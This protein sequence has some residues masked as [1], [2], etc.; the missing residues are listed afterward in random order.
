MELLK[1]YKYRIITDPHN[2][3]VTHKLDKIYSF[4][5]S[6]DFRIVESSIIPYYN[7]V[8][9]EYYEVVV[10]AEISKINFPDRLIMEKIIDDINYDYLFYT[11][12]D[13][14]PSESLN[15]S[16]NIKLLLNL[17]YN[18]D[19]DY[20]QIETDYDGDS[21]SITY[22]PINKH[23]NKIYYYSI[24]PYTFNEE[25]IKQY[26]LISNDPLTP[27]SVSQLGSKVNP[28]GSGNIKTSDNMFFKENN[29]NNDEKSELFKE[30]TLSMRDDGYITLPPPY[31]KMNKDQIIVSGECFKQ[32][33][34]IIDRVDP[35]IVG[36][37]PLKILDNLEFPVSPSKWLLNAS[38]D[39]QNN[40]IPTMSILVPSFWIEHNRG[41]TELD[42][43]SMINLYYVS[44]KSYMQLCDKYQILNY[45][46]NSIEVIN[47]HRIKASFC[48][49]DQVIEFKE[50]LKINL[51]VIMKRHNID[52]KIFKKYDHAIA[53]RWKLNDIP[54]IIVSSDKITDIS[55][56]LNDEKYY[57]I[58]S[59]PIG[60]E[61]PEYD[62]DIMYKECVNA[63]Y[64]YNNQ[65]TNNN[66][67][68][69][70][71]TEISKTR[72]M[73]ELLEY[74]PVNDVLYDK[75]S[76]NEIMDYVY[77]DPNN[78][79]YKYSFGIKFSEDMINGYFD[80]PTGFLKGMMKSYPSFTELDLKLGNLLM[81][82]HKI[83]DHSALYTF[84]VAVNSTDYLLPQSN[85]ELIN[86][87]LDKSNNIHKITNLRNRNMTELKLLS[88]YRKD[89]NIL[90]TNYLPSE[91]PGY[92]IS[93]F[94]IILPIGEYTDKDIFK[95]IQEYWR[96]GWMLSP[97]SKYIYK[98]T[99]KLSKSNL[100]IPS[101]LI[102]SSENINKSKLAIQ[103]LNSLIK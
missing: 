11:Y 51:K 62:R 79:I 54:S 61:I 63:Y 26:S 32:Y 74:Y 35:I 70:R 38:E 40:K 72:S 101:F 93:L 89:L 58:Y 76:F 100:S 14:T 7:G 98:N 28:R 68:N 43:I 53:C 41:N 42:F 47:T 92:I 31:Y 88:N 39:I 23:K 94:E 60:A 3:D 99:G 65:Y 21:E 17:K 5:N 86:T 49:Y 95:Y 82:K 96:K 36:K 24:N 103:L 83:S 10:P 27:F 66:I 46:I 8:I 2:P 33:G 80:T 13:I 4:L 85:S 91:D 30:K 84:E 50:N 81:N 56:N 6:D 97:W 73:K 67:S 90:S 1:I 20:I 71:N 44:V 69:V 64:V 59:R 37:Y 102:E 57:V 15:I 48:N 12:K 55:S 78:E 34:G 18:L 75:L 25:I 19:I 77:T 45:C 9:N 22:T 87:K 52:Y 29:G 16:N